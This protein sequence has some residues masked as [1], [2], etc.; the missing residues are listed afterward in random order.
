MSK[1]VKYI[2]LA[3]VVL[4]VVALFVFNDN[5][6]VGA[7]IAGVT[8]VFAAVKSRL[9]HNE[10][11]SERIATIEG[12]HSIKRDEWNRT[13]DEYDSKF[14]AMKAR[15]DYLDYK[16]KLISEQINDLDVAEQKVLEQNE[17][18]T[19]DEILERLNNL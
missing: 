6:S 8:A 18:L 7:I 5:V 4:S 2:L 17:N 3:L 9:I 10:P 12:E 14:R 11:L 1:T 15:M 19:D 16:S 13:K